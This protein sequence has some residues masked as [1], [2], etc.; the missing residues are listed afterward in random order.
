MRKQTE[1]VACLIYNEDQSKILLLKRRD[2]P[3]WV[4]PGGGIDPGETPEKA[5]VREV[6][7]E[8][9]YHVKLN[10]LIAIYQPTNRMTKKTYF[11]EGSIV[12]GSQKINEEAK[13]IA[14]F[15]MNNLPY[16][17]PPPYPEWIEDAL[18]TNATIEKPIKSV[19][20]LNLFKHAFSHPILVIRFILSR[21]GI[22]INH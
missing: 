7:E 13:E 6:Q 21:I 15:Q 8:T 4:M 19:T 2:I 17:F 20:Y 14:F 22:H 10:R 11:Y 16:R 1:S 3:V 9:G 18:T 5:I 12:G